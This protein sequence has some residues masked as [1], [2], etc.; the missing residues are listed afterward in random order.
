MGNFAEDKEEYLRKL[1]KNFA[2]KQYFDCAETVMEAAPDVAVAYLVGPAVLVTCAGFGTAVGASVGTMIGPTGTVVGGLLG[3]AGGVYLGDHLADKATE[4]YCSASTEDRE[5][6]RDVG[7]AIAKG[8]RTAYKI[9]RF[10][11]N[12]AG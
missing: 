9:G 7:G 8:V 6:M 12:F 3:Y 1:R 5:R 11:R 4:A 10:V 2:D